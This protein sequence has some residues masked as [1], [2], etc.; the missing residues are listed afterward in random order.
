MQLYLAT[1][2]GTSLRSVYCNQTDLCF[3]LFGGR[4]RRGEGMGGEGGD[5]DPDFNPLWINGR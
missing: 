1:K 2:Y 3:R 4:R 5:D